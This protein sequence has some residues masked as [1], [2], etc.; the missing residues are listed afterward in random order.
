MVATD[1]YKDSLSVFLSFA[2]WTWKCW[3]VFAFLSKIWPFKPSRCWEWK[4]PWEKRSVAAFAAVT[5]ASLCPLR[6][7]LILCQAAS[8]RTKSS[9]WRWLSRPALH[10]STRGAVEMRSDNERQRAANCFNCCSILMSRWH[11]APCEFP[12]RWKQQVKWKTW[13]RWRRF[14]WGNVHQP[15]STHHSGDVHFSERSGPKVFMAHLFPNT[16][17]P[18]CHLCFFG[19][20]FF[21][22]CLSLPPRLLQKEMK[23]LKAQ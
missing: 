21:C 13:R 7:V 4:S 10:M 16:S 14:D 12:F 18:K 8:T 17:I 22:C 23:S 3:K 11:R 9:W 15:P 5:G 19:L 20:F 2:C 1:L 6:H